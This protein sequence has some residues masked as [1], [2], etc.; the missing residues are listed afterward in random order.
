MSSPDVVVIGGGTIGLATSLELARRGAKVVLV[1]RSSPGREASWAAA[2][3][4][5]PL[6]EASDLPSLRELADASLDLWPELADRLH[7]DTGV[8]VEYRQGGALHVAFDDADE[9]HLTV[10]ES[11]ARAG[12]VTRLDADGVRDM[13]PAIGPDARA[14]LVIERDHR[15]DNRRLGPALW[16][17]AHAAGVDFR[18]GAPVRGVVVENARATG[19]ALGGGGILVAGSVVIAAGAWSA[20]L[21][22]LPAPLPVRPVRGQMFAVGARTAGHGLLRHVVVTRDCYLVPREDGRTLVGATVEDVGFNPG[23]TP[24]GIRELLEAGTR[25]APGMSEAPL[26]ETWAGYR[27]GTPD[28]RPILGADPDVEHLVHATGHFRNGILLTPITARLIADVTLGRTPSLPLD[29][30]SVARFRT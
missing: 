9:R 29:A 18:L 2:G 12:G 24:A 26:V 16:A 11:R 17:S 19:V 10:L 5:S 20:G 22:G 23:P 25:A 27:P 8:D 7:E 3:M 1:E 15:V 28:D 6:G 14:G 13:E 30:F 4:L 21:T